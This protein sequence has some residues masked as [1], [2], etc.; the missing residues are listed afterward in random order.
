MLE[1]MQ[2]YGNLHAKQLAESIKAFIKG[3][4]P[5]IICENIRTV[6]TLLEGTQINA[7]Y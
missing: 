6:A 4:E 5:V 2:V 3:V 7:L 1:I